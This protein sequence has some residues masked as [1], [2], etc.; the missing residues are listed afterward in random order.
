MDPLTVGLAIAGAKKLLE[1]AADLKDVVGSL[2]TLFAASD[3]PKKTSSDDDTDIKVVARD[4]LNAKNAETALRNM[5][6]DIDNRFGYG[7]FEAIKVERDRRIASK[8][9]KAKDK[10][11]SNDKFYGQ[12]LNWMTEFG[13]VIL[14]IALSGGFGYAIWINRCLDGVC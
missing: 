4:I 12:C 11:R 8:K 14:I 9:K 1:T 5:G 10:A 7:T 3:K 6:I 2:E 13:K